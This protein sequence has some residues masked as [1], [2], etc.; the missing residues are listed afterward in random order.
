MEDVGDRVGHDTVQDEVAHVLCK[1]WVVKGVGREVCWGGVVEVD[2]GVEEDKDSAVD[3]VCLLEGWG[4]N[5]PCVPG[6]GQVGLAEDG[7]P[8]CAVVV[9]GGGAE[10][11]VE[12]EV[13]L[14]GVWEVAVDRRCPVDCVEEGEDEEVVLERW[15]VGMAGV[16]ESLKVDFVAVHVFTIVC[17]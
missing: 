15:V 7:F 5:P 8:V 9:D 14:W 12:A 3:V 17:V 1:V 6:A 4:V 10:G 16:D 2:V 11:V 13:W